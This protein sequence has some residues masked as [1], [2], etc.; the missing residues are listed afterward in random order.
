MTDP[1]SPAFGPALRAL[2]P[3]ILREAKRLHAERKAGN[4][5][6]NTELMEAV[7]DQTLDR[8]RGGSLEESWWRNLLGHLG[9]HY[10]TPDSLMSPATQKWLA[11]DRVAQ[12]LKS[13][14]K[15]IVMGRAR[16]DEEAGAVGRESDSRAPGESKERVVDAKD[17]VAAILVAGYIASIPPEQQPLAAMLQEL[18]S[19]MEAGFDSLQGDNIANLEALAT[20]HSPIVNPAITESA[21]RELFN[22][23]A[24]RGF[25]GDKARRDL[26]ELLQRLID[27]DLSAANDSIKQ[28]IRHWT[29]RLCAMNKETLPLA[30][31]LRA[32]LAQSNTSLNLS[33]VDALIAETEGDADGAL[34]LL[35][36]CNDQASRSA[37]FGLVRRVKSDGAALEWF[38][39]Q[40][41]SSDPSFLAPAGWLNWALAA[42]EFEEWEEASRRLADLEDTWDELPMLAVVEGVINAAM[43]LPPEFRKQA[44]YGTPFFKG[45]HPNQGASAERYHARATH[46]FDFVEGWLSRQE[47]GSPKWTKEVAD[48]VLWLRLMNPRT[49]TARAARRQV[50]DCMKDGSKAVE[51]IPFAFTFEIP[52]DTQCL[53]DFLQ[54]RKKLGG[55]NDQELQAEFLLSVLTLAAG[56]LVGYLERKRERLQRVMPSQL[57]SD[58]HTKALMKSE[59][60][61]EEV[62]D[63][64]A[65]YES[66]LDE[67]HIRRLQISIDEYGDKD[68]GDTLKAQYEKTDSAVDL[69]RLIAH[70]K[71]KGD[72][73]ALRPLTEKLFTR[74]RTIEHARDVVASLDADADFDHDSIVEFLDRNND[75]LDQS[76]DLQSA[77][78]LALYRAGRVDE[79]KQVNDSVLGRRFHPE[80]FRLDLSI[81]LTSGNWERLGEIARRAWELRDSLDPEMLMAMGQVSG[82]FDQIDQALKLANAAADESPDD[83][84]I[85][86]AA[87][88]LHLQ[89]GREQIANPDWLVRATQMSSEKAGPIWRVSVQELVTAMVPKRRDHERAMERK[90]LRGEIPMSVAAEVFNVSLARLLL[91]LPRQ[92]ASEPDGRRKPVLPIIAGARNPVELH[93]DWTVGLDL[94]SVL[95]LSFLGLLEHAIGSFH[96]VKLAP[97]VME[98]LFREHGEARFHQPSRIKAAQQVLELLGRGSILTVDKE[99]MVPE[100][101]V[102]EIGQERASLLHSARVKGGNVVCALP[103]HKAGSLMQQEADISTFED[104]IISI[105]DFC[106]LCYDRGTI[107]AD[108]YRHAVSLLERQGQKEGARLSPSLLDGPIYLDE[109]SLGYLLDVNLLRPIAAAGIQVHISPDVESEM[110]ALSEAGYSGKELAERIDKVRDVLRTAIETG[111][112]SLLP[113]APDEYERLQGREIRFD[114]TVSLLA[115]ASACDALCIDDRYINSRPVFTD[116]EG[117]TTPIVCV[118]EVL[119][120][121]KTQGSVTASDA[122][123]ARHKLRQGGFSFIL[124]TTEE[125]AHWLREAPFES[126]DLVENAELRTLRQSVARSETLEMA[127]WEE[128]FAIVSGLKSAGSEVISELWQD[129]SI[130]PEQAAKLSHWAWRNVVMAYVPRRRSRMQ[131]SYGVLV[132][133][134]ISLR[135]G[136]LLFPIA[137]R[138]EEKRAEYAKWIE[139]DILQ[140][141]RPANWNIVAEALLVARDVISNLDV[142]ID[143]A[144]FGRLVLDNL[145]RSARRHLI[146]QDAAFAQQCGIQIQRSLSIGTDVHIADSLLFD[147]ARRVYSSNEGEIIEDLAGREVLVGLDEQQRHIVV[148]SSNA[149]SRSLSAEIRNLALLSPDPET[150]LA[151]LCSIRDRIGPTGKDLRQI[152]ITLE[153]HAPGDEDLAEI[154]DEA[155]NGVAAQQD[156]LAAIMHE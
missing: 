93:E 127:N 3:A 75:L 96:H 85:L 25:N 88:W 67:E 145:P 146:R 61:P 10:I 54:Q 27:G 149:A 34:C 125:L 48:W 97:N 2:T 108:D 17:A 13:I 36:D 15:E 86:S 56:E 87:Y 60:T 89:L 31:Q 84:Y 47:T 43:L 42:A 128:G 144:A 147:A 115:G 37:W 133:G 138:S 140:S 46:C 116:A 137:T 26:Q 92:N 32:E 39:G 52:F 135:L 81:A 73:A 109:L 112:A 76:D 119:R 7:F 90:W 63:A 110:R 104:L 148:K 28:E 129:E 55:L 33:I 102:N 58:V 156:S 44:L 123:I 79:S 40:E 69:R 82:Q 99:A 101:L 20:R 151:T 107:G 64:A 124:P 118:L 142:D 24:L 126:Q 19:Q 74:S 62:Q 122:R 51:A 121:L 23:L 143:K 98:L 94:S 83:P 29:A 4:A 153:S 120:Y 70:L 114:A 12:E 6:V 66:S 103:I 57:L 91:D 35:R 49:E 117:I 113:R 95:V 106:R 22:T 134:L 132:Q 139:Q 50:T 16:G 18:S 152:R 41:G 131:D 105:A 80:N 77:K 8:L 100:S 111:H 53:K 1:I 72:W 71:M 11:N 141:L 68:I 78:A 154:L 30:R 38:G 155:V 136:T 65:S 5:P 14:A 21:T 9:Q 150:R 130:S 59:R 45:V